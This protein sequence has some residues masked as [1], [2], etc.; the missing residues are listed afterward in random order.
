MCDPLPGMTNV[1]VGPGRLLAY[2]ATQFG[3]FPD[4]SR[5]LRVLWD[6]EAKN[7]GFIYNK[8]T[9]L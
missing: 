6:S 8:F 2:D 3:T 7:L 9:L 4:G 1:K 5:Q